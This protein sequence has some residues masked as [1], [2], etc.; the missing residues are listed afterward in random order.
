MEEILAEECQLFI[1]FIDVSVYEQTLAILECF[2]TDK[3]IYELNF[4]LVRCKFSILSKWE[5]INQ[6]GEGGGDILY[7]IYIQYIFFE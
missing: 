7:N 4:K 1:E 6:L 5:F 2:Q 3:L